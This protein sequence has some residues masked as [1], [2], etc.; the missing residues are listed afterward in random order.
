MELRSARLQAHPQAMDQ[1]YFSLRSGSNDM[2]SMVDMKHNNDSERASDRRRVK[3]TYIFTTEQ[4]QSF[5][6]FLQ[7]SCL[8][9]QNGEF[10]SS[11]SLGHRCKVASPAVGARHL[12][13]DTVRAVDG[14][15]EIGEA[16]LLQPNR[17]RGRTEYAAV[18]RPLEPEL[19]HRERRGHGWVDEARR[20]DQAPVS[21]QRRGRHC[22]HGS[23]DSAAEP[24]FAAQ[25]RKHDTQSEGI[26]FGRDVAEELG[27]LLDLGGD[28]TEVELSREQARHFEEEETRKCRSNEAVVNCIAEGSAVLGR[29]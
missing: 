25:V 22:R 9:T 16:L 6:F 4:L 20:H 10:V 3:D 5:F 26:S 7:L 2:V 28:G 17:N 13:E 23:V 15:S 19:L 11:P 1:L 27:Q 18:A 29:S 14:E 8:S 21:E 24:Y 12:E